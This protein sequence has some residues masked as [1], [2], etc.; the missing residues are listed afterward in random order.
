M[1][2]IL[3]HGGLVVTGD[4]AG[5]YDVAVAGER[6]QSLGS[7]G[8]FSPDDF[9]D[10]IDAQGL[11]VMPGLVEPHVHFDAPF[12]GGTTDH[13]MLTGTKACAYGGITS[14]ISFSNQPK[15]ASLVQNVRDWD[16][17][18]RGRAY[19]D[20]SMHG[21]VYDASEQTLRDIPELV[22][23]GVP[24]Y[25]C[26]T[27][28][29]HSGRLMDDDSMLLVLHATAESGGMLMVHCEHDATCEYLTR[30][31]ITEGR[32]DW[33]YHAKTRPAMA[34]DMAIQR[35]A[36]LLQTV[37]APVYIVHASTAD[38]VRIVA[39]AQAKGLPIRAETCTHYL[40]LTEEQLKGEDGYLYICSPPLRTERDIERLWNAVHSGPIEVVSSDDAGL[41]SEMRKRLAEGRFDKVPS[42]MPGVEP[43]LTLLYSEGV[44]KNRFDLPK[45]VELTSANPGRLF[46]LN[47]KGSLEPG[48]DA[49]IVLFD[50]TVE[51][52]MSAS[53]LHMNTDFC[54]FE[55]RR[56]MGKSKTL[57]CRGEF[58]LRD[59][60]LTGSPSHGRRVFRKL[61]G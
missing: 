24:T 44:R 19:V 48:S 37:P 31:A 11:I 45:L 54:P 18:N 9:D 32:T 50:P 41:P 5:R 2:R 49:D 33:I 35:V 4:H 38:S 52:I 6:I 7:T 13:D 8:A 34:E 14:V 21:L 1:K 57:L 3:I 10:T 27:T 51:W 20:W 29:R 23:L 36:D 26:F 42:G 30:K 56:V 43:R 28:Y 47:N 53:T 22:K 46:G 39:Q 59:F 55:G 15:G 61:E 60:E 12:M 17:N 58:V 40:I 16:E 25:K